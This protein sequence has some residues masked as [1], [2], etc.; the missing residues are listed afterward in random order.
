MR[1]KASAMSKTKNAGHW[2]LT[3][4]GHRRTIQLL[5]IVAS[6]L[7]LVFFVLEL[8]G[9]VPTD[10]LS[11]AIQILYILGILALPLFPI[12]STWWILSV[13]I[14]GAIV[15]HIIEGPSFDWGSWYALAVLGMRW[16]LIPSLIWVVVT[17]GAIY[18]DGGHQWGWN[19]SA[20][21]VQTL[22]Y[23]A[24]FAIGYA[25]HQWNI[26]DTRRRD[27]ER[28]AER[29]KEQLDLLHIMHDSVATSLSIAVLQCRNA[30]REAAGDIEQHDKWF[31]VENRLVQT[32]QEIRQSVIEPAKTDLALIGN[33]NHM[34]IKHDTELEGMAIA[35]P[36][37]PSVEQAL[38]DIDWNLNVLGF[39]GSSICEVDFT[40]CSIEHTRLVCRIITELGNNIAKYGLPPDYAMYISGRG[41]T[42]SVV[43]S[44]MI[45]QNR[46][47]D[48]ALS[49][50][51]GLQSL[52]TE[53]ESNG[54]ME[55][56][57]DNGEWTVT[58]LLH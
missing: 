52:R 18:Y 5:D 53:I 1:E 36:S 37:A 27:V 21:I 9:S 15:P 13:C 3:I 31:E 4:F 38:A 47:P 45:D 40:G 48:P 30:A 42:I 23:I 41:S 14:I 51:Y 35:Q 39:I 25:I 8:F 10:G 2:D 12:P 34:Q 11:I 57:H 6:A 58:I 20:A 24:S 16:K 29:R 19:D 46:V 7:C 49:S 50:G 32:L 28:T 55:I 33:N 54:S 43:S 22:F 56:S 44:N 17:S 26:L